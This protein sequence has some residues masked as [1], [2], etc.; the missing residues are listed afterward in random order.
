MSSDEDEEDLFQ[1]ECHLTWEWI[2]PMLKNKTDLYHR[3]RMD[4]IEK[5]IQTRLSQEPKRDIQNLY[6][7]Q[8][9]FYLKQ[10][11]TEDG[12]V[13]LAQKSK[14]C[15]LE[16]L[17]ECSEE[18]TGYKF[19]IY[20]NLYL[21]S[22]ALHDEE[23]QNEY[24]E[25]H[26]R[27]KR[28]GKSEYEVCE[29]KGFAASYLHLYEEGIKFTREA[30][31]YK[32]TAAGYFGL[33]IIMDGKAKARDFSQEISIEISNY[34]QN[35]IEIDPMYHEAKLRLA[36]VYGFLGKNSK[37]NTRNFYRDKV[38]KLINQVKAAVR[39]EP[40][41]M[42]YL[43]DCAF[44]LSK[45]DLRLGTNLYLECLS[46]DEES[47]KALRGLGNN[48]FNKW[49]WHQ[50]NNAN[51]RQDHLSTVIGYFNTLVRKDNE[52]IFDFTRL[53]ISILKHV[54]FIRIRIRKNY[55]ITAQNASESSRK[56]KQKPAKGA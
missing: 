38:I 14:D 54:S 28:E 11:E 8:G 52:K 4:A 16:A 5:T 35:A 1:P 42:V 47:Q 41:S 40:W 21:C 36:R 43:E 23:K 51:K 25:N 24:R 15:L 33:A 17:G 31:R 2:K 19:I 49:N 27:L 45:H 13:D 30:L 53:G 12:R 3:D 6:A 55:E 18:N 34:L 7:L 48:F 44:V 32:Q 37:E 39:D 22:K 9:F 26:R 29:M 46:I 56:W 10:Y 20:G 50:R